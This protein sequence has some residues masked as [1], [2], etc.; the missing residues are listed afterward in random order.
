[1]TDVTD[2]DTTGLKCPLPVL[3]AKKAL[4]GLAA[5]A[6]LRVLATDPDSVKD[7]QNFCATTGDTL[8]EWSEDAG[9]FT[10]LIDKRS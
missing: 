6:T 2:L 9:I 5:G 4:K 7:F 1:M 8:R 3:K 10:Y